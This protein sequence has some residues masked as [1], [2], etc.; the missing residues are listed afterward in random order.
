[1]LRSLVAKIGESESTRQD[2][3][4][5]EYSSLGSFVT[6]NNNC[7]IQDSF[8]QCALGKLDNTKGLHNNFMFTGKSRDLRSVLKLPAERI[9][10][11]PRT[12]RSGA[13]SGN[14]RNP[15]STPPSSTGVRSALTYINL[16]PT[17]F[18]RKYEAAQLK[19]IP[20]ANKLKNVFFYTRSPIAPSPSMATTVGMPPATP[21][22]TFSSNSKD[23]V[24]PDILP[25]RPI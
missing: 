8:V 23:V 21:S 16:T 24:Q 2:I 7:I 18:V 20:N 3:V 15:F 6:Y 25:D 5:S 12:P 11:D 13:G 17:F 9:S 4:W 10:R 22:P 14:H 1:M 19:E